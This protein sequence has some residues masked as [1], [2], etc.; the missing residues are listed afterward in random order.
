MLNYYE[1]SR[2]LN[3]KLPVE[4]QSQASLD[5]FADFLQHNWEQRSVFYDD[6][7]ITSRQQFIGFTGQ[8]SIRTNNYIGTI[9]F[10]GQQL[11]IFPKIFRTCK[12]DDERDDLDLRHLMRNLVRWID[13]C[14]KIDYP[15]IKISSELED[16]NDL[17]ELFVTLYIR[18]VKTALDRGLYYKYEDR[19]EDIS[20]IKGRVD[21]RDYFSR[22]YPNGN[23]DKFSCTYSTFEFDNDLNRIIKY[24]CKSLM[25]EASRANQK[26]IR[27]ILARLNDVSDVRC[28]PYDC[29]KVRLSRLHKH[30]RIILSMSKMFLLNKS[31]SYN[32]D[33]TESF[34]FL[35]PA[36][37]LFEGFIGGFLKSVLAGEAKVRLQASEEY[38]FDD[39][40]F[41]GKS[42]GKSMVMKH[43]ILVD[44]KQK[45][46][47]ILDTKYKMLDRFM[48]RDDKEVSQAITN[49]VSSSDLYQVLTYAR[50]R[51]LENVYLLYPMFRYEDFNDEPV[52]GINKYID[53]THP[54]KVH[55]IRLPFVFEDDETATINALTTTLRKIFD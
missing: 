48:G 32:V 16:S 19:T 21:Y 9:V 51:Q 40:Q 4:W 18:Y 50:T 17:R 10:K 26:I 49:E 14:T 28:T 29:N 53:K 12:E 55:L 2:I 31:S 37:L 43:D 54:I 46:V 3:R 34:C 42:L 1:E 24:V 5:E 30:Y 22:K 44:H 25:N 20:T 52:V 45:G 38:L 47:F 39:V 7:Q 41:G 33:D 23:I 27:L 13:Y 8:Q 11:N 36:E 6:G 15:Y 35:F